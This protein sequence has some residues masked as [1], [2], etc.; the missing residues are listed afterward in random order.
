MYYTMNQDPHVFRLVLILQ[1]DAHWKSLLEEFNQ[2]YQDNP[3]NPNL[4]FHP[5]INRLPPTTQ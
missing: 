4:L 2:L 5:I 1:T 3:S